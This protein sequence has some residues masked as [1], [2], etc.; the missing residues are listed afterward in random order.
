MNSQSF[1]NNKIL[2]WEHDK[3][4]KQFHIGQFSI[5]PNRSIKERRRLAA[6]V[7]QKIGKGSTI[8]ELGCGS[9]SLLTVAAAAGVKRY[10][11]VDI[12]DVAIG[13]AKSRLGDMIALKNMT[14]E[15]Q[16]GNAVNLGPYQVDF[17]FSLGFL[18]WLSPIEIQELLKNIDCHHYLHS[19]SRN[20]KS[21][22]RWLHRLYVHL[23]YGHKSNGYTPRYFDR[24]LLQHLFR[25]QYQAEPSF[26]SSPCLSFG[27]FIYRLPD[28]AVPSNE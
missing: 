11:G 23:L 8:L 24:A 26:Y 28:S 22:Q 27:E 15:L 3:Y 6:Q 16:Q 1:W 14:I 20:M 4:D 7:I 17:C 25:R 12:S 9:A 10:I 19:Y 21:V 2:Q 18:D 13:K 5:D